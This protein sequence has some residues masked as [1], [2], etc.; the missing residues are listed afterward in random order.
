MEVK[1]APWWRKALDFALSGIRSGFGFFSRAPKHTEKTGPETAAG[2]EEIREEEAALTDHFPEQNYTIEQASEIEAAVA[3]DTDLDAGVVAEAELKPEAESKREEEQEL[4]PEVELK[5]EEE[6]VQE[7]EFGLQTEEVQVRELEE[8]Q[9]E[10]KQA[11]EPEVQLKTEEVQVQVPETESKPEEELAPEAEVDVR[12][13]EERIQEP[14]FGLQTEEV[15]SP[16]PEVELKPEEE[17]V[18]EREPVDEASADVPLPET[19]VEDE[20]EVKSE[21]PASVIASAVEEAPQ[22][23]HL[24]QDENIEVAPEEEPAAEPALSEEPDAL[25]STQMSDEI[26]YA[27][28]VLIET[29]AEPEFA[30]F[31]EPARDIDLQVESVA[32]IIEA[33]PERVTEQQATFDNVSVDELT[34][35]AEAAISEDSAPAGVSSAPDESI[36]LVRPA[37]DVLESGV[38]V[39]EVVA[40]QAT[41][42]SGEQTTDHGIEID[43]VVAEPMELNHPNPK[44]A[45]EQKQSADNAAPIAADESAIAAQET[46]TPA[47]NAETSTVIDEPEAP[48]AVTP[49][50]QHP[51][52]PFIKLEAREGE[53]NASPFSVI[54]SQVYDG[55]L[56]LLLDL[57]RK[58]DIDIYDIPIARI[59]AQFLTYVD[60]LKA[61]DVDVAGEFIYTA[62]LLIHIKSKMLLPRTPSG[63]E[64]AAEDPRRELVERLLEH[65]RFK[66][67]AQMLQ[68][69][70]MLEAASWTNP[71]MREFKED[72]GTEP[73]IAA[74]TT[75]LVRVFQDILERL[76][77]RP[78]LNVEEDTVTVGQMI[79]FLSRRLTMEDKP[80]AL[81]RL[82]SHTR[83]ER[84]LIAMFL[85]LLEL[86]RLQ[87]I[88]LRQDR[89][90]SEIFI[91]K[92]SNFENVMTEVTTHDDWR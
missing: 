29:V 4:E 49:A 57:I 8:L 69:K 16:E 78:V 9:T 17:L 30:A 90:F 48:S 26:A 52:K 80:I 47:P 88:L 13:E 62:S 45:P 70:Q 41:G 83:S 63:P 72:A 35:Q 77:N 67:A 58:Q 74:D 2:F 73:E 51:S 44:P 87:A 76:R 11:Q 61:T 68:Q 25:A 15:Q 85:A 65:E 56:D 32:P 81:R 1:S 24:L 43:Q 10:E 12:S 86:V 60:Q 42:Q 33:A 21:T 3:P 79:Q 50:A 22:E 71:G 66:N 91:K 84:A 54:V 20:I 59:T 64:D 40:D 27:I 37:I 92:Q 36:E 46:G 19:M 89:A 5:P 38:E 82:L 14:E 28:E 39:S 55:P 75:D 23:D 7:P 31:A 6:L 18:P 34:P 53:V